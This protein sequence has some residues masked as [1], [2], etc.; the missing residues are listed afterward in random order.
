MNEDRELTSEEIQK[1]QAWRARE[2]AKK[3]A[4]ER[5]EIEK[6]RAINQRIFIDDKLNQVLDEIGVRPELR[7]GAFALHRGKVKVIADPNSDYGM[8]TIVQLGDDQIDLET[9]LRNWAEGDERASA[10]LRPTMR[11]GRQRQW[12]R[13][14]MTPAEKSQFLRQHGKPAYDQLPWAPNGK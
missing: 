6:V 13:S 10:Y 9:Y 11:P 5:A 2:E 1:Y 7:E 12:Y 3:L 4:D 8:A 14:E